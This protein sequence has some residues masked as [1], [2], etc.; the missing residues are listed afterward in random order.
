MMQW[1][2]DITRSIQSLQALIGRLS[3]PIS[4]QC[5]G[6]VFPQC[7]LAF[8]GLLR[9]YFSMITAL[10]NPN[11]LTFIFMCRGEPR[12]SMLSADRW[13]RPLYDITLQMV[14]EWNLVL[15]HG[16]V[17]HVWVRRYLMWD[18]VGLEEIWHWRFYCGMTTRVP[19]GGSGEM[20]QEPYWR[21]LHQLYSSVNERL[22]SE[23]HRVSP[24]TFT[25]LL[26]MILRAQEL[27]FLFHYSAMIG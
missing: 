4:C 18:D 1:D 23:E 20:F 12:G 27:L 8:D 7:Q 9:F 19:L 24:K 26:K 13:P 25:R 14:N 15:S 5:C 17:F 10:L 6:G 21:E 22:P 11:R 2:D 3:E 16:R